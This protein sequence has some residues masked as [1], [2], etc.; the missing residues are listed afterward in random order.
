MGRIS[1]QLLRIGMDI[2]TIFHEY[3]LRDIKQYVF[4]LQTD[5]KNK[6]SRIEELIRENVELE[7]Q[8]EKTKVT[9][10]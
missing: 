8:I 5:L 2:E 4:E 9:G 10:K 7:I 1:D 3:S 6:N